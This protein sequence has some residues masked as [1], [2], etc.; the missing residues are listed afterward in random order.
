MASLLL[1]RVYAHSRFNSPLY[2][3]VK[4]TVT[5]VPLDKRTLIHPV[6]EI[7]LNLYLQRAS[8][9]LSSRTVHVGRDATTLRSVA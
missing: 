7:L 8:G 5:P 2:L 3:R 9:Y 1:D 4:G 6:T